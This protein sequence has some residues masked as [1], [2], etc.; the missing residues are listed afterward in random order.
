VLVAS[1]LAACRQDMHDQPRYE[2]LE[3]SD[4]FAD[5]RTSRARI[6][7]TVARGEPWAETPRTTGRLDGELVEANPLPATPAL[8]AR[9]RERYDVFCAVCHDRV[10]TGNGLIVQRGYR[11]PPTLHDERLRGVTDGYLFDVIS[12][13][14]G[15][16]PSYAAQIPLDDRWAI[17]AYVRALQL[18][19]WAPLDRL[20]APDRTRLAQEDG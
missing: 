5:G 18:S 20:D 3:V 11:Q 15:V 6:A 14:F 17:I 8:L 10:G 4:F 12:R 9:G 7:G 13:G 1:G 16:M 2:P 19:Q